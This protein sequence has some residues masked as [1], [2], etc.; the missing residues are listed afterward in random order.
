[1]NRLEDKKKERERKKDEI[2]RNEKKRITDILESENKDKEEK[3][4]KEQ[5]T[6]MSKENSSDTEEDLVQEEQQTAMSKEN[7]SD[8]KEDHKNPVV[9][10]QHL[11]NAICVA[12][13]VV[14]NKY[15]YTSF[16]NKLPFEMA[17]KK[18]N[19]EMN[20]LED[21]KKERERKKDEIQR[22]EKK[23]ITDILESTTA[24]LYDGPDRA[25]VL[26]P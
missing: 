15:C 10:A 2:Q 3:K 24:N 19:N 23:R 5:Q 17:E 12:S 16:E 6:A 9:T 26:R 7:S 22:N 11:R 4:I 20:R 14:P 21:K 1:M 13:H 25:L 18:A 8:T